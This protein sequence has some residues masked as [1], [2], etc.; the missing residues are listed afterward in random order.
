MKDKELEIIKKSILSNHR[1]IK[2][3]KNRVT[4]LESKMRKMENDISDNECGLCEI[5]CNTEN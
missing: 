1:E 2:R 3:L 5:E 4:Y